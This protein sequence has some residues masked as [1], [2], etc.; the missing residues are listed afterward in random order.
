MLARWLS[1][2]SNYDFEVQHR[3]GALHSNAD[4][5][6][7]IPSRRCKHDDCEECALKQSDCVCVVTR[8]QARKQGVAQEC[9]GLGDDD[10][11]L[12]G[13]DSSS[14]PCESTNDKVNGGSNSTSG[15]RDRQSADSGSSIASRGFSVSS[16]FHNCNWVDKW[17]LDDRKNFQ[18]QDKDMSRMLELKSAGD[19]K[20]QKAELNGQSELFMCMCAQWSVL[21]VDGGLLVCEW[22]AEGSSSSSVNQYVVPLALRKEIFHHLH[23][24][25]I[26]GHF[27]VRRT[28]CKLRTRFYWPGYKRDIV[29]GCQKCKICESFKSG[30][31][32]KKAPL[33]QQLS[34]APLERIACDIM[35]PVVHSKFVEAYRIPDQTAQTVANYLVT[36]WFCHYGIPLVI[37]TDQGWN[38]ESVLFKELCKLLDMSKTRTSRYRPQSDGLVECINRILRQLLRATVNEHGNDWDEH[39][40]YVMLAYRSTVQ[41]STKCTPN[42]LM[43]G[44]E[45]RLPVD[46]MY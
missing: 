22:I 3:R 31:N 20:L 9:K 29:M 8:G 23:S 1:V 34:G 25:R 24:D 13:S 15:G 16:R 14:V 12:D 30:H 43:F 5:L 11:G 17:S 39:L 28:L 42:L 7:R 46:L 27:G 32:P 33:K 36:Q 40:P 19:A 37:H 41:E 44:R 18:C 4:G 35:G 38:Y 26:G 45:V 6:S 10:T 2:L 21:K